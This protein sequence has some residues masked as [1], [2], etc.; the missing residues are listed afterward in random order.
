MHASE[1]CICH[2]AQNEN[3]GRAATSERLVQDLRRPD[4]RTPMKV[5]VRKSFL[6]VE[7]VGF[8]GADEHAESHV[9]LSVRAYILYSHVP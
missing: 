3:V 6:F 7:T 1:C 4:R 8:S 9:S 5:L 2:W